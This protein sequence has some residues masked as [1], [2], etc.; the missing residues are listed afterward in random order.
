MRI[1]C[2]HRGSISSIQRILLILPIC[3]GGL[4][5]SGQGQSNAV[6]GWIQT[7]MN[8]ELE[9]KFREAI[10]VYKDIDSQ[11]EY[12]LQL[13]DRAEMNLGFGRCFL[14]LAQ[15]DTAQFFLDS[16]NTLL[17]A[18]AE[19][20]PELWVQILQARGELAIA[21]QDW[22]QAESLL[23]SAIEKE[24][25]LS[26]ESKLKSR[27]LLG[28]FYLKKRDFRSAGPVLKEVLAM[29]KEE[30]AYSEIHAYIYLQL[31]IYHIFKREPRTA[32]KNL[33]IAEEILANRFVVEHP[34]IG[35][36]YTYLGYVYGELENLRKSHDYCVKA[37]NV[38]VKSLGL[39]HPD[40][41]RT[42][43]YTGNNFVRLKDYDQANTFYRQAL[44]LQLEFYGENTPYAATLYSLMG[45]AER[46]MRKYDE[47]LLQK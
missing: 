10:Q 44:N 17:E 30:T 23:K 22:E 47:A 29:A 14:Y 33:N 42:Y 38:Q 18:R 37:R 11:K 2:L 24:D 16:A 32:L 1:L 12:E 35:E 34:Y 6:Q 5:I 36:I 9:A 15:Y 13:Q 43:Y 31:G 3:I 21:Q 27:A 26:T 25:I 40:L 19:G 39:R 28:R 46:G 20:W 7:A 8:Y 45:M 41:V 4:F